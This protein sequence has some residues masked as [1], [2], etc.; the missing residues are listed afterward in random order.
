MSSVVQPAPRQKQQEQEGDQD[1]SHLVP[2]KGGRVPVGFVHCA[3]G[4]SEAAPSP[5]H[6][7]SCLLR[8]ASSPPWTLRRG[9]PRGGPSKQAPGRLPGCVAT[10]ALS[11][12]PTAWP[13]APLLSATTYSAASVCWKTGPVPAT[14]WA[15][16]CN[17]MAC[18]RGLVLPTCLAPAPTTLPSIPRGPATL[19]C[20]AQAW[21]CHESHKA[22]P[23]GPT[24]P[25][26][27]GQLPLL[28]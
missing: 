8:A 26:V 20:R 28:L 3:G 6:A 19:V 4:A 1:R 11:L 9:G 24:T 10:L 13:P 22:L 14:F 2:V 27:L 16:P 7:A 12:S 18:P 17:G 5:V 23:C 21:S 15:K 25:Q